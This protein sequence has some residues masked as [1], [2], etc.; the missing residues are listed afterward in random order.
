MKGIE[1]YTPVSTVL[2]TSDKRDDPPVFDEPALVPGTLH[3]ETTA[4]SLTQE[5]RKERMYN[6]LRTAGVGRWSLR[7]EPPR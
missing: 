1:R 7:T 5:R 3:P 4:R 2:K 6:S